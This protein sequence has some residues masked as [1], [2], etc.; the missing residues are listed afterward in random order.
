MDKVGRRLTVGRV[1][2]L[3]AVTIKMLEEMTGL[4]VSPMLCSIA[5]V[6]ACI[7]EHYPPEH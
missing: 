4:R 2:P 5:E 6:D 1:C 7:R 3:D